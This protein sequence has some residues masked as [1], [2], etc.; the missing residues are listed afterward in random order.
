IDDRCVKLTLGI[1]QV[2]RQHNRIRIVPPQTPVLPVALQ[3][4]KSGG[5]DAIPR[6]LDIV[7]AARSVDQAERRP[8]WVIAAEEKAVARAANDRLHAAAVGLDAC[9][10]RVVEPSAVHRTP[11]V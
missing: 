8:D 7:R 10:A 11:E 2:A 1:G 3:V 9:R 5:L 4:L 6:A